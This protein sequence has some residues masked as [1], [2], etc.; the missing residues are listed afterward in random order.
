M[1][2]IIAKELKFETLFLYRHILKLHQKKLNEEMRVLGD[3]FLKSEFSLNYRQADESQLKLFVKEWNKYL[4]EMS[5][6]K[7][8][9]DIENREE[10]K[11]KMD[12]DQ[13]KSFDDLKK[14]IEKK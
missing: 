11:T 7:D 13:R 12:I 6:L 8:I 1:S 5:S 9:Y 3:Y 10:L 2:K 14:L 4:N